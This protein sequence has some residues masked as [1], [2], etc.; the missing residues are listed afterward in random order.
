MNIYDDM[1]AAFLSELTLNSEQGELVY[2]EP[3]TETGPEYNPIIT[4]GAE[5]HVKGIKR[6]GKRKN[7]YIDGG[8]IVASDTLFMIAEFGEAPQTSGTFRANG[9]TYQ[10][11][12][13][14]PITEEVPPVGYYLGL[15]V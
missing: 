3:G 14:D 13:V 11:I 1:R 8:Y 7:E 5:H 10:I 4:P 9:K 6:S 12:M 15:R 2:I